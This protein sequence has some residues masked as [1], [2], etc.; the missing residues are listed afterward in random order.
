MIATTRMDDEV[1]EELLRL[2]REGVPCALATVVRTAGSTP[3]KA[4]A[5]MLVAPGGVVRGTIGGGR[6]EKEVTDAALALLDEGQVAR[7]RLLRFHLTREL[8]MCCG[9]EM[10]VFIEP[11]V[12]APPLVVVGGGHVARALVPMAERVGFAP[13]VADDLDEN[14]TRERFPDAAGFLDSFDVRD[15]A[16]RIP[17]DGRAY[18]VIVTRDHAEDQRVLEQLWPREL[19][20]LGMIGSRRKIAMFRARLEAKGLDPAGWARVHA[21]IGLDIGAESPEEIAVAIVAELIQ[22]R[23]ARRP[24]RARAAETNSE[25]NPNEM[26]REDTTR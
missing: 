25:T 13:W 22:T 19:A 26:K 12:P 9:G 2:R 5:R 23:A 20:Y 1:F 14:L 24:R 6:V 15:W 8:A 10:E 18:V 17:L 21:P 7:P 4:A 3:R 11:M 16:R